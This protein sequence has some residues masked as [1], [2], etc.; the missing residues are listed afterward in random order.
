MVVFLI[1]MSINILV[2]MLYIICRNS[3]FVLVLPK[4]PQSKAKLKKNQ[5]CQNWSSLPRQLKTH[6]NF[7]MFPILVTNLFFKAFAP[8]RYFFLLQQH[9]VLLKIYVNSKHFLLAFIITFSGSS[10]KIWPKD[11]KEGSRI[12]R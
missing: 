9:A 10:L 11:M 12:Y 1:Y 4:N 8:F 6:M 2:R 3:N 7:S 5:Y